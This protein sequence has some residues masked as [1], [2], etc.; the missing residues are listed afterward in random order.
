MRLSIIIPAFNEAAR[1]VACL[2]HLQ[3]ALALAPFEAE[4]IVVDNNSCDATARLA[5]EAGARV[6]FEPVNQIARARNRGAQEATA[7]WLLFLDA[8]TEV[9]IELLRGIDKAM[10]QEAS[11]GGGVTLRFF[12]RPPFAMRVANLGWNVFSRVTRYAAGACIFVRRD[13]FESIGG[14]DEDYFAGEE[15]DFS[16]RMKKF[17]RQKRMQWRILANPPVMT[18]DRKGHLY[19]TS[20]LLRFA[21]RFV[22]APRRA[23]KSKKS[24]DLWY[25]G[26]R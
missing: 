23:C 11:A 6:V 10:E 4:I 24:C 14:F 3:R 20:R 22:I 18:S 9:S 5:E 21:L 25:D 17:A 2:S 19:S 16:Q 8:D 12:P 26:K 13:C 7:P 15:I 1:I